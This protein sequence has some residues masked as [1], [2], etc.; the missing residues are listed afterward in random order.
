MI[1]PAAALVGDTASVV[2]VLLAANAGGQNERMLPINNARN[3][4]NR[5]RLVM[6]ESPPLPSNE[7]T[8]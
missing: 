3:A 2:V 5:N 1:D 6:V 8:T 7:S 4:E